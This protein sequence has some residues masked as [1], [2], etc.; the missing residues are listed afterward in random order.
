MSARIGLRDRAVD[1]LARAVEALAGRRRLN[2]VAAFLYWR[3]RGENLGDPHRNGEYHVLDVVTRRLLS[4]N[5]V[6]VDAGA[7][8]GE[9]SRRFLDG[10]PAARVFAFEPVPETHEKLARR[11][12]DNPRVA[13]TRVA[14]SDAGG[15]GDMRVRCDR[16]N[17]GA[18]SLYGNPGEGDVNVCPVEMVA[19]DDWA[20]SAGV[21]V[22]D[23][24]KIDVEGHEIAVLRG[25]RRRLQRHEI[26]FIQWEYNRTWISARTSILDAFQLLGGAG[27]SLYKIRRHG[28]LHQARYREELD[29]FSYSNWLAIRPADANAFAGKFRIVADTGSDC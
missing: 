5:P 25:F 22:I 16:S 13:C 6:A 7:N 1:L 11:F 3:T 19:G 17:S 2:R 20:D 18:N 14:L 23:F 8:V 4:E 10:H 27:Y 21:G 15:V 24:L 28:L 12:A 26:R 29:N 9:W